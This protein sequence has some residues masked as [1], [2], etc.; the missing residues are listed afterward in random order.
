LRELCEKPESCEKKGGFQR[1]E[2]GRKVMRSE[3]F[4][5]EI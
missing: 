1:T 4:D 3:L 5:G 2:R